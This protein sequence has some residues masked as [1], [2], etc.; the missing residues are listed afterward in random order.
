MGHHRAALFRRGPVVCRADQDQGRR[1]HRCV[2]DAAGRVIGDR[3][4]KSLLEILRRQVAIDCIERRKAAHRLA[5]NGDPRWIDK[6]ELRQV[7]QCCIGVARLVKRSPATATAGDAARPEAVDGKSHIPPRAQSIGNF[8]GVAGKAAAA[9]QHDDRRIASGGIGAAIEDPRQSRVWPRQI[10]R[11][12]CRPVIR[13]IAKGDQHSGPR[14]PC[15]GAGEHQDEGEKPDQPPRSDRRP[16][17]SVEGVSS[18]HSVTSRA[19]IN[20]EQAV[21]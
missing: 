5:E 16:G 12:A 1:R 9:M 7:A 11:Q 2:G 17:G 6:I 13:E 10:T 20:R 8:R 21:T 4:A 19:P 3:G 14:T 15:A 18:Y